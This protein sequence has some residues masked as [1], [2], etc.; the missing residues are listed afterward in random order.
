METNSALTKKKWFN[1]LGKKELTAAIVMLALLLVGLWLPERLIVSTSPS[2]DKRV[3][4]KAPVRPH[5]VQTG[6]YLVF[7]TDEV[8]TS[9]IEEGHSDTALFVKKVGCRPGQ[10]LI[11]TTDRQFICDEEFL[12]SALEKDGKGQDLPLFSYSGTVPEDS[13][14]MVGTNARSFDSKYFGFVQAHDI[15]YKALPLW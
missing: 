12:G 10:K 8:D 11:G 4:F 6:D 2:L 14:F 7:T 15:L 5:A 3:F 13:F 1:K 9:H